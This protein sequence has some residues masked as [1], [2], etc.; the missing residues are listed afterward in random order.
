MTGY[1]GWCWISKTR[2]QRFV[3]KLP[4]NTN[5]N[6]RKELEGTFKTFFFVTVSISSPAAVM[7]G[8]CFCI[9]PD[10]LEAKMNKANTTATYTSDQK[11]L[12]PELQPAQNTAED[13]KQMVIDKTSQRESSIEDCKHQNL[14]EEGKLLEGH[15]ETPEEMK[16]ED[17]KMETEPCPE[18][19]ASNAEKG[20]YHSL[21]IFLALS[22]KL[23]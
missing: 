23:T 20:K 6:Y 4:G 2:V 10:V 18:A 17:E 11:I 19:T 3:P 21:I 8:S 14:K 13:D 5:V 22:F 7:F 12:K 9:F 15:M 16:K 1:G